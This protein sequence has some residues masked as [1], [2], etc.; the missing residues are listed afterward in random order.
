MKLLLEN[1]RKY[2]KETK[3]LPSRVVLPK[4]MT[5]EEIE[6]RLEELESENGILAKIEQNKLSMEL[7][8]R[9]KAA[10]LQAMRFGGRS[11]G[12]GAIPVEEGSK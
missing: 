11:V 6:K 7:S 2:L 12:G 8:K 10:Q 4:F 3:G 9:K 1:W 5:T